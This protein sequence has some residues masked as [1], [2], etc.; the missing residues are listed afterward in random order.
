MRYGEILR[1]ARERSGK[2]VET[3]AGEVGLSPSYLR[4]VEL[5][6]RGALRPELS[7]RIARAVGGDAGDML[8]A[9]MVEREVVHLDMRGSEAHRALGLRLLAVWDLLTD[10]E[11]LHV[12]GVLD[13]MRL[14]DGRR[15]G[16]G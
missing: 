2:S 12:V 5:G 15:V 9:G 16:G 3:V 7:R 1:A 6:R 13:G 10:A 11:A 4:D 8:R 14:P